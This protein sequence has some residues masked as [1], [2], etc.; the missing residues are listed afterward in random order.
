[1]N[2]A[3]NINSINQFARCKLQKLQK[4]IIQ[5]IYKSYFVTKSTIQNPDMSH[6]L[7]TTIF[8]INHPFVQYSIFHCHNSMMNI[9]ILL[10]KSVHVYTFIYIVEENCKMHLNFAFKEYEIDAIKAKLKFNLWVKYSMGHDRSHEELTIIKKV[11]LNIDRLLL[12][13]TRN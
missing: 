3:C 8:P 9:K 13:I 6:G 7:T 2:V 4:S 10:S 1:M 5:S 12:I 11:L